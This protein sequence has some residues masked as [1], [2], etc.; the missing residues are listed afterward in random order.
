MEADHRTA[1]RGPR[2]GPVQEC[3]PYD[4]R[5]VSGQ[6]VEIGNLGIWRSANG[7][8][9]RDLQEGHVA[10]EVVAHNATVFPARPDGQGIWQESNQL[11][12]RPNCRSVQLCRVMK[13]F[14]H[15]FSLCDSLM[16]GKFVYCVRSEIHVCHLDLSEIY[17]YPVTQ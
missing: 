13:I 6:D 7:P 15:V 9:V 10:G 4:L 5:V 1:D 11:S 8:V 12:T 14:R 3:V 2:H 17:V 16:R